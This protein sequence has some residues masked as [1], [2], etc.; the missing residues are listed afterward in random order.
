MYIIIAE[1]WQIQYGFYHNN[2]T[3]NIIYIVPR[4]DDIVPVLFAGLLN[5]NAQLGP[6]EIPPQQATM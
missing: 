3:N 5:A 6:V 4:N 2:N 1:G